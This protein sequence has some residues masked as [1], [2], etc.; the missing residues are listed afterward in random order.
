M[1]YEGFEQHICKSGHQF[2]IPCQ[3]LFGMESMEKE[4]C[5]Y[6]QEV[7][8][9]YNCVDDTNYECWG[10]INDWSSLLLTREE[11]VICEFGYSHIVTRATYR[12]PT[13]KELN[14]LRQYL[15]EELNVFQNCPLRK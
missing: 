13:K 3:F 4:K 10:I 2:T 8:A 6:C 5:P 14:Q 7:S 9:W 1:S 11:V 12:V 15:D